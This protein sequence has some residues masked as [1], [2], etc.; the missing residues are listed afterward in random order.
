[1][2]SLLFPL[3]RVSKLVTNTGTCSV[4]ASSVV[5]CDRARHSACGCPLDGAGVLRRGVARTGPRV[6]GAAD[7]H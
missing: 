7:P 3:P 6:G 1:M 2:E 5:S 4:G